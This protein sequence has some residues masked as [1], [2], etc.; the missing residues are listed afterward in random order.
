MYEK[1]GQKQ[2]FLGWIMAKTSK[3]YEVMLY[4][5]IYRHHA[6]FG[7]HLFTRYTTGLKGEECHPRKCDEQHPH[8]IGVQLLFR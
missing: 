6:P 7:S 3:S 4:L 5:D 1:N 2:P 8:T